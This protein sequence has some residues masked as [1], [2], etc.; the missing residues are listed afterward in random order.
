MNMGNP[1]IR[2][3][4]IFMDVVLTGRVC[5]GYKLCELSVVLQMMTVT[6]VEWDCVL[7]IIVCEDLSLYYR[8][9]GL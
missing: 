4:L 7:S 1:L 8:W 3:L 6:V 2:D 5:Y 9:L